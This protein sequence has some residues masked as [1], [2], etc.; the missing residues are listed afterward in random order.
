MQKGMRRILCVVICGAAWGWAPGQ[1]DAQNIVRGPTYVLPDATFSPWHLNLA[2]LNGNRRQE[3]LAG[4]SLGRLHVLDRFAR[5][6]PGW[7]QLLGGENVTASAGDVNGD[8]A[9]EVIAAV[10]Q[11]NRPDNNRLLVHAYGVR[12][13]RLWTHEMWFTDWQYPLVMADFTG[14]CLPDAI[15]NSNEGRCLA[16]I[17]QDGGVMPGWPII[18]PS[19]WYSGEQSPCA[20]GDV[21]GDGVPDIAVTGYFEDGYEEGVRVLNAAGQTIAFHEMDDY[22]QL[23][24]PPVMGDIDGDG[25]L[26]IVAISDN[27]T[28]Y[29]W[30]PDGSYPGG[31]LSL[32][33]HHFVDNFYME[34]LVLA[35]ID[36]DRRPEIIITGRQDEDYA[37]HAFNHDGTPVDLHGDGRADFPLTFGRQTIDSL[38]SM[39]VADID[40]EPG[41]ELLYRKSVR[42]NAN[43]LRYFIEARY[44][45]GR[46]VAGFPVELP[47]YGAVAVG[48]VD[49]DGL[50]E[51]VVTCGNELR[52]YDTRGRA[53]SIEWGHEAHD[54]QNT[55]NYHYQPPLP[56]LAVDFDILPLHYRGG[57]TVGS[58]AS[59]SKNR[60]VWS[61][62][63]NGNWD[64]YLYDFLTGEERRLTDEDA[65]QIHPAL[66]GD[67]LVW[68]EKQ[69]GIW[70][71]RAKNIMTG[72]NTICLRLPQQ[73]NADLYR[74]WIPFY[75]K[76]AGRKV[77]WANGGVVGW[78]QEWEHNHWAWNR[79]IFVFDLDTLELS[80]V[81]PAHLRNELILLGSPLLSGNRLFYGASTWHTQPIRNTYLLDLATGENRVILDTP[82]SQTPLDV[83]GDW[84]LWYGWDQEREDMEAGV[85]NLRSGENRV[86]RHGANDKEEP[87]RISGQTVVFIRGT[88]FEERELVRYDL[89]TGQTRTTRC[90]LGPAGWAQGSP[91]Y[92][93][94][95][96]ILPAG[97]IGGPGSHVVA[98]S[99]TP[100]TPAGED[101]DVDL[102]HG[103]V[104]TL[105]DV[106][107]E[108]ETILEIHSE[109]IECA[110]GGTFRL[111]PGQDVYYEIQT[112]ARQ[113]L[114][115]GW[116]SIRYDDSRM[117]PAEEAA[118]RLFH[119]N[120]G[121]WE[122]IT[123]HLDTGANIIVGVT[124]GFS[125]FAIGIPTPRVVWHV[126]FEKTPTDWTWVGLWKISYIDAITKL[127]AG[128]SPQRAAWFG[129]PKKGS[130]DLG[131][132]AVGSLTSPLLLIPKGGVL[133]FA[134]W[135]ETEKRTDRDT[136]KVYIKNAK[137]GR[138][139]V[140]QCFGTGK[141][142]YPVHID[143]S[144]YAG[145]KVQFEFEF[146]SVDKNDN[147]YRGWYIDD[148]TL[149]AP[150]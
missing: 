92:W 26:E 101:V 149:L 99:F 76:I 150:F 143:L 147:A 10:F 13:N 123:T 83:S 84:L 34:T 63:R 21:D 94:H 82:L 117:T 53:A 54:Y 127:T 81:I 140:Y 73:I 104:V 14:D 32:W 109:P 3:I 52:I 115:G 141:G 98:V 89:L 139:M 126:N 30:K 91:G 1:A 113:G 46:L 95:R 35:D 24:T 28:L 70:E 56:E 133:T 146:D 138:K 51:I 40:G 77:Y 5:P 61:E 102:G 142:W 17:D 36:N 29:A 107:Q 120:N 43:A 100:N 19:G 137:L 50:S 4:D 111:A 116:V 87:A 119:C 135:E 74:E 23:Y 16:V 42:I 22:T 145:Q 67:L 131:K 118:L 64:I 122:D 11:P 75:P 78:P 38:T 9:L 37:I 90:S 85:Y 124:D 12:A 45:D 114:E 7:P 44:P 112:S 130:Y 103:V 57:E 125:P 59:I 66:D 39:L 6:L 25:D 55:R 31:N 144:S 27:R 121:E 129:D 136:R 18:E 62:K 132:R 69:N 79:S 71:V 110:A 8:G 60:A 15:V 93:G 128:H 96:V 105:F 108:G 80:D 33:P 148:V 97:N 106:E 47:A 68:M 88:W 41:P 58:M 49:G 65:I 86:L 2:D 20:V 72:W 48:D 134:S